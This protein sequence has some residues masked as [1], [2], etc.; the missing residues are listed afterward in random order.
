MKEFKG[1]SLIELKNTLREKREALRTFRFEV[2]AGKV[3]NV[4]LGQAIKKSIAMILTEI[5]SQKVK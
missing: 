5:N 2:M 4:K 3:K 1:K